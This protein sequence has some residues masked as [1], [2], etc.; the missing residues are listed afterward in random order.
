M[1]L[2][3]RLAP[4]AIAAFAF[5]APAA[6]A[7]DCDTVLLPRAVSVIQDVV[8]PGAN[9]SAKIAEMDGYVQSCPAHGWIHVMASELDL[10]VFRSTKT[11]NGGKATQEGVNFLA[12][13]FVRSGVFQQ[14]PDDNRRERYLLQT[15]TGTVN[16]TY[17]V[18]SNNR[19]AIIEALGDL[20]KAGTIHPYLKPE[21]DPACEGW[22]VSDAQTLSYK[23][24]TAADMMLLPFVEAV[25]RSCKSDPG[26]RD[27]LPS[28]LLTKAYM[29]LV[30]TDAVTEKAEIRRLLIAA[31]QSAEDYKG[32][33]GYHSIFFSEFDDRELTALSRKHG[34]LSG[35]EPETIERPL[36]FSREHVGSELA[37]RSIVHSFR[38]YWTPL[39]AGETDAPAEEV[40]RARI[41]FT[42]YVVQL[43]KQGADAGLPDETQAMLIEAVN[44][45]NKGEILV[46]DAATTSPMPSWLYDMTMR[47][48]KPAPQ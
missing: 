36:W 37:I 9:L 44:A 35:E 38:D 15:G 14:G 5:A 19:S 18:A 7:E 48:L 16:L 47:L 17:S 13:A 23:V 2:A 29:K 3:A 21:T 24:T 43:N 8:K 31:R 20:A 28:A 34:V 42:G 32:T 27:R 33:I 6:L 40:A 22:A 25:A 26:N 30:K 39:A 46:P 4:L 45:F 1:L 11:S 41:A 12:R 10:M